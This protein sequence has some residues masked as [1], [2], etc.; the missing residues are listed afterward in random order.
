MSIPSTAPNRKL[1]PRA[2]S[3]HFSPSTCLRQSL[4]RSLHA[5]V[6]RSPNRST[7][8]RFQLL[9]NLPFTTAASDYARSVWVRFI[10]CKIQLPFHF[11]PDERQCLAYI[12][13]I[14]PMIP[15]PSLGRN[16]IR[17][18]RRTQRLCR[19]TWCTLCLTSRVTLRI[20]RQGQRPRRELGQYFPLGGLGVEGAKLKLRGLAL[21]KPAAFYCG[22]SST[23]SI[24]NLP[25]PTSSRHHASKAGIH[26][27]STCRSCFTL[28]TR[29]SQLIHQTSDFVGTKHFSFTGLTR[30]Q[31]GRSC[32]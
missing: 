23:L 20:Y 2:D 26:N 4:I 12:Q 27:S 19:C 13:H 21:G 31:S 18:V 7:A 24:S 28:P 16:N 8:Q 3:G 15:E 29:V 32:S 17:S 14:S 25:F 5:L 11:A 22:Q 6:Q 30:A 1:L 9:N 10:C